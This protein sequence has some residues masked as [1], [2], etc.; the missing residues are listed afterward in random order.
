MTDPKEPLVRHATQP[1]PG[2]S[3][4]ASP[5]A[6]KERSPEPGLAVWSSWSRSRQTERRRFRRPC[7]L[8][9]TSSGHQRYLAVSHSHLRGA[10]ALVVRH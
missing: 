4:R 6:T 9:A 1:W 10:V 7:H 8:R 5:L 2:S 3:S